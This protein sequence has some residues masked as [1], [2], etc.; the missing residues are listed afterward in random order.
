M[1]RIG[2][3]IIAACLISGLVV[4]VA[5]AQMPCSKGMGS[6]MGMGSNCNMGTGMGA[7]CGMGM[8]DGAHA[9]YI[10][11]ALGLDDSQTAAVKSILQQL[12]KEMIKNEP[13]SKW[14]RS[15]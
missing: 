4:A 15:R 13:I 8:W 14:Q 11:D 6:G 1:K 10:I 2:K 5:V 7:G 12:Q 9:M 3:V